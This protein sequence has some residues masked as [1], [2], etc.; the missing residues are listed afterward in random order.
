MRMMEDTLSGA[1]PG[2]E[3][4]RLGLWTLVAN[5]FRS[6]LHRRQVARLENLT[7]AELLDIGLSRLDLHVALGESRFFED[8][9][10]RLRRSVR[11]R[12]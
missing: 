12:D 11:S 8:P 1:M 4:P 9:S 3:A 5:F 2:T 6:R 7:D 10:R